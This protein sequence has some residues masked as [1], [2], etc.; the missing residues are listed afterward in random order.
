VLRILLR[1]VVSAISNYYL[2]EFI[3][4]QKVYPIE[5]ILIDAESMNYFPISSAYYKF[6]IEGTM[7]GTKIICIDSAFTLSCRK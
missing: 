2:F 6:R 3:C 4:F 1:T 5:N 7:G